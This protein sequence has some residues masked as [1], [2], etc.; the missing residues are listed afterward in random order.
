MFCSKK[1]QDLLN[2]REQRPEEK[3]ARMTSMFLA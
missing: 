2:D 1:E 3:M